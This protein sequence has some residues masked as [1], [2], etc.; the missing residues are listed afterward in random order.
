MIDTKIKKK[1]TCSIMDNEDYTLE[2]KFVKSITLK[3]NN[4][5]KQIFSETDEKTI[6]EIIKNNYELCYSYF[7]HDYFYNKII[8]NS[9]LVIFI[10]IIKKYDI[11][12]YNNKLI[13]KKEMKKE[14]FSE[15]NFL[16]KKLEE[17]S[18]NSDI[19]ESD[20]DEYYYYTSKNFVIY[21]LLK[22]SVDINVI[23]DYLNLYE[24][25]LIYNADIFCYI[26]FETIENYSY[27]EKIKFF[28]Y[29]NNHKNVFVRHKFYSINLWNKNFIEMINNRSKD[30]KFLIEVLNSMNKFIKRKMFN[31][32][33]NYILSSFLKKNNNIFSYVWD[34]KYINL[35]DIRKNIINNKNIIELLIEKKHYNE[36]LQCI[37]KM[38]NPSIIFKKNVLNKKL[39]KQTKKLNKQTKKLNKKTLNRNTN[40]SI[41]IKTVLLNLN[42]YLKNIRNYDT[43]FTNKDT[44]TIVGFFNYII[45]NFLILSYDITHIFDY[46]INNINFNYNYTYI[47]ETLDKHNE[48][49]IRNN[50]DSII[51]YFITKKNLYKKNQEKK[52]CINIFKQI[53]IKYKDNI[54]FKN[55]EKEI[56]KNQNNNK[57]FEE[58]NISL[59]EIYLNIFPDIDKSFKLYIL[60]NLILNENSE[61]KSYFTE[62][63]IEMYIDCMSNEK[64][65][66][67]DLFLIY[68]CNL[69]IL[70]HMPELFKILFQKIKNKKKYFLKKNYLFLLC[71]H[72][73]E[74]Q[75][76]FDFV[77]YFINKIEN[78]DY[79]DLNPGYMEG[80][81][82]CLTISSVNRNIE[83]FNFLLTTF[84]D[85]VHPI[86]C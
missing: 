22:K 36:A 26:F 71:K 35:I 30:S 56:K 11:Y 27:K 58:Y 66:K 49:Y 80:K 6:S 75:F 74:N 40:F 10:K 34:K 13:Y 68:D 65:L 50:I 86:R 32:S 14:D 21:N 41:I 18:D 63:Y 51:K 29:F 1:K 82:T 17:D 73:Y 84:G 39:N 2:Q 15:Q 24:E 28:N 25:D 83:L 81:D 67:N 76:I 42:N 44:S 45:K 31:K 3:K 70:R 62:T 52:Y 79:S 7:L 47:L 61:E 46:I 72:N 85:K 12:K 4:L 57:F 8:D 20:E 69:K 9:I 78:F 60:K 33:Y 55:I 53:F 38:K 48:K 23:L 77:N 37:E 64:T 43:L 59:L 19:D 54:N 5:I 16:K